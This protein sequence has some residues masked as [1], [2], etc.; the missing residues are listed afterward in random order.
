MVP[1]P[2]RSAKMEKDLAWLRFVHRRRLPKLC[3]YDF[4]KFEFCNNGSKQTQQADGQR[5]L[6]ASLL[7]LA[8]F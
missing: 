2:D 7:L 1:G 8:E 5:M 4:L 3:G 6:E